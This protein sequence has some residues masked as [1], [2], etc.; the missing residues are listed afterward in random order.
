MN[1]ELLAY[2]IDAWI[3][4]TYALLVL[5]GRA[6]PFHWANALGGPALIAATVITVGWVPLLVLTIAFTLLGWTGLYHTRKVRP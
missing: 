4:G 1:P 2:E 3:L 6:R 5:K